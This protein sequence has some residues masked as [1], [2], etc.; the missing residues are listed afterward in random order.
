MLICVLCCSFLQLMSLREPKRQCREYNQNQRPLNPPPLIADQD[1]GNSLIFIKHVVNFNNTFNIFFIFVP[2]YCS[3]PPFECICNYQPVVPNTYQQQYTPHSP[4][5]MYHHHQQPQLESYWTQ[6]PAHAQSYPNEL[7]ANVN[8]QFDFS[9]ISTDLFQPEEIFQLDQPIKSD[10]VNNQNQ[11]DVA[12]SPPTLLDLG[13]GTIHRE[14]KTEEYWHHSLSTIINDDSNNS[15]NSRFNFNSSPDNSQLSNML[16]Q[17]YI[18]TNNKPIENNYFTQH[19]KIE[20]YLTQFPEISDDTKMF[21][22]DEN[23][24]GDYH[25][26]IQKQNYETTF[27]TTKT[28]TEKYTDLTEY[29]DYTNVLTPYENKIN[30][31]SE[32]SIFNEIDFRINNCISTNNSQQYT[33][34]N[35]NKNVVS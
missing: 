15:N 34:D 22:S 33:A 21:F 30:N 35:F 23:N 6:E 20:N 25:Q 2:G 19:N 11:N 8:T 17:N 4:T 28:N 27:D 26:N 13:S 31:T 16:Q 3:C 18:E 24:Y 1:K 7:S 32:T 10:Y 9:N 14:F 29:V 5:T 12:R